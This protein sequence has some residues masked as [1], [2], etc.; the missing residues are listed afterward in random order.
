MS[1]I[2]II[3]ESLSKT[4]NLKHKSAVL[5]LV[6]M[7][8]SEIE[9]KRLKKLI[10]ISEILEEKIFDP[11]EISEL[12]DFAKVERYKLIRESIAKSTDFVK[13]TSRTINWEDVETELKNMDLS[14]STNLHNPQ[15]VTELVRK[16]LKDLA[17][18]EENTID[19]IK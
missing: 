8:I 5:T 9:V 10:T 1:D 13:N 11:E 17:S 7:Q 4:T 19:T 12:P 2:T 3:Q 16:T 18:S 14:T 15:E 6:L